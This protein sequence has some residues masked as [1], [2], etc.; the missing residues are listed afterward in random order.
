MPE[1]PSFLNDG[2]TIISPLIFSTEPGSTTNFT[3]IAN[4]VTGE[5]R[6]TYG[7][8]QLGQGGA[9]LVLQDPDN[10]REIVYVGGYLTIAAIDGTTGEVIWET[11]TGL[12]QTSEEAGVE[13]N[14][15][16]AHLFGTSYDPNTDVILAEYAT[17]DILAFDR[18][19]GDLVGE[20]NLREPP[21]NVAPV[22]SSPIVGL[23]TILAAANPPF[24]AAFDGELSLEMLLGVLGGT[25]ESVIA[26]F[27][28][29]DPD[30]GRLYVAS[31]L[32]DGNEGDSIVGD[33]FSEDGALYRIDIEPDGAG[34]VDFVMNC[35]VPFD[36]GSA[37]TPAISPDGQ[38]I[39]TADNF[40]NVLAF[41][42]NCNQV[43]SVDTGL[44]T[45]GSI[46]V[47]STNNE[48]F[49]SNAV[50]VSIIQQNEDR[51]E[52]IVSQQANIINSFENAEEQFALLEPIAS[53]LSA[54]LGLPVEPAV[55]NLNLA[56][57]GENGLMLQT[58]I[59][60]S[61]PSLGALLGFLPAFQAITLVDREAGEVINSTSAREETVAVM[62]TGPDGSIVIGNAPLRR[63]VLFGLLNLL[64]GQAVQSGTELPAEVQSF[65]DNLMGD[66]PLIGG[67]TRYQA[68][69]GFDLFARDAVC[70]AFNR[71][72]L[73][74]FPD[75]TN[76][77]RTVADINDTMRLVQQAKSI[78]V[79]NQESF[80]LNIQTELD[81]ILVALE[82]ESLNTALP[83]LQ[84]VCQ[85]LQAL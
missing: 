4:E 3:A 50:G 69:N 51:T 17:G 84:E 24:A 66:L 58:G 79:N 48:V 14:V 5:R 15:S 39:Y 43:W 57:V 12:P 44:Q 7:P 31:T 42:E 78:V 60:F 85:E 30:N 32:P 45:F 53:A 75:V 64:V 34:G 41:D 72:N 73:T 36:G 68:N 33:G 74:E 62:S 40:T 59:G 63:P 29:I 70:G 28:G 81:N 19:T 54:A 22:L 67:I 47:S 38:R 6:W 55:G 76:D 20:V 18:I 8:A 65:I 77:I 13:L 2:T 16:T 49:A 56:T 46:G 10:D 21:F 27:Y 52:A 83:L 61:I 11:D 82:E 37:A 35:A 1:G 25:G 23:E 80:D 71:L 9:P 26:N